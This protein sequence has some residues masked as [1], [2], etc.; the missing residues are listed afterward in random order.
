MKGK[1]TKIIG[2]VIEA[3][4][5]SI[6]LG[7]LC[8]IYP[9]I[10]APLLPAEV[11]GFREN[12][13]LLMPLGEMQGIGPGSE[14]VSSR[15]LLRVKVGPSLLGRILDGLGNPIDGKGP[16]PG[17]EICYRRQGSNPVMLPSLEGIMA[18]KGEGA[19]FYLR[20]APLESN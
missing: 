1:I 17:G 4:G 12:R 10:D 6:N 16:W 9:R 20:L 14:V 15:N 2:L 8:Y 5:P 11:V 13:V 7:E 3:D 19:Q 18:A